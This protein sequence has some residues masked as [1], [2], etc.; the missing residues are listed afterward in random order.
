[1]KYYLNF[2]Y[3]LNALKKQKMKK[4]Y[5]YVLLALVIPVSASTQQLT[6]FVVSASGGFYE[7]TS[8]MLSFTTG[9]LMIE[10]YSIPTN[11]LTQG[12]QQAWDFSTSVIENPKYNLSYSL[13]PNPSA[14]NVDV[15]IESDRRLTV[16][17]MVID[18]LGRKLLENGFNYDDHIHSMPLDLSEV[19][20]GTY[21]VFLTF[22]DKISGLTNQLVE[23]VLIIR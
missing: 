6:P 23:K 11:I 12:F 5:L 9:E 20:E 7:N 3:Y 19:S 13:Y 18:I 8:G 14:G 4:N 2:A 1:M 16:D 22:E 10:S 21:L 15:I 17:I